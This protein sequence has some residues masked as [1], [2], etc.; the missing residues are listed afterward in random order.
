MSNILT[1]SIDEAKLSFEAFHSEIS[2]WPEK[3]CFPDP[4]RKYHVKMLAVSKAGDGYQTDQTV[5]T[6]GCVCKYTTQLY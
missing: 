5:S 2:K 3:Y 1:C 4:R 6:P